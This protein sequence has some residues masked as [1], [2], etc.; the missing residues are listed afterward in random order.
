VKRKRV[1]RLAIL[2]VIAL[3][4]LVVLALRPSR[5]AGP[6]TRINGPTMLPDI[7]QASGLA[8]SRRNPGVIWSHNDSGHPT[9]FAVDPMGTLLGRVVV[10]IRVFDWEDIAVGRCPGG[11]CLYL[12]DIGDRRSARR[13]IVI[14]RVPEPAPGDTE[15][16]APEVFSAKYDDSPHHA[17]AMFVVGEDLFVITRDRAGH[18]YRSLP[19][20][21]DGREIILQHIA[22]LDLAG[23]TDAE[24]LPDEKSVVVRTSDEAVFYR[25]ADF[26]RGQVTPFLRVPIDGMKEAQGEGVAV[27]ANGMLYLASEGRFWSRS[28][29]LVTLR[30]N[31]HD[32]QFDS[33]SD[34]K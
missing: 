26:T 21:P 19:P 4:I 16:A 29:R 18:L 5:T 8:V 17:E 1:F 31:L 11:V 33:P 28:G 25:T 23:V 20:M 15:T 14:Y 34:Q 6:C 32:A 13:N 10:P 3:P 22:Q 12:A 7:P 27:D 24:S 30:C 9:L 2:G